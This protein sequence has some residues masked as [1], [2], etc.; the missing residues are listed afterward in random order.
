MIT[1]KLPPFFGALLENSVKHCWLARAAVDGG[2]Q[3]GSRSYGSTW[4]TVVA[5]DRTV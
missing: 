4:R 3:Q 5:A 2:G 1:P